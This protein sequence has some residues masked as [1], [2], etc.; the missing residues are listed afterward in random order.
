MQRYVI[1][2][3]MQRTVAACLTDSR[4]ITASLRS[5]G[6]SLVL[7]CLAGCMVQVRQPGSQTDARK[8][9]SD[10]VVAAVEYLK[11]MDIDRAQGHVKRALEIDASAAEAHNV[12]GLIYRHEGDS[13]NEEKEYRKAISSDKTL[14]KARNN[15]AVLLYG[16]GRYDEAIEQLDV[17]AKDLAYDRRDV[18][19][20][21]L[22]RCAL[23]LNQP[24][25]AEKAFR[26]AL[27]MNRE[28]SQSTLELAGLVFAHGERDE[29]Y[30]L[31]KHFLTLAQ[32][33]AQSL[34]L[35][36]RLERIYGD[37]NALASYELALKRLYP[38]TPEYK[39]WRE[40]NR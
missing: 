7:V 22:G 19:F 34:W 24:D 15:Y 39:A 29:A 40:S 28:L 14:S 4:M 30:R 20:E 33:N 25:R 35:G 8:A 2:R 18:V 13:K 12:M 21:N 17:A 1:Q 32:Q 36:I 5:I 6:L 3:V 27:S 23:K 38:E 31:Y 10:H 11:V 16:Q 37:Q 9:V 26:R